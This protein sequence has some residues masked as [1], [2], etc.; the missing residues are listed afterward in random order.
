MKPAL[1]IALVVFGLLLVIALVALRNLI[2]AQ[3]MTTANNALRRFLEA[4]VHAGRADY[5]LIARLYD[6][7]ESKSY[8]AILFNPFIWTARQAYPWLYEL[9]DRRPA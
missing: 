6:R 2:A 5:A 8:D 3:I 7:L 1:L 4:E 9:T